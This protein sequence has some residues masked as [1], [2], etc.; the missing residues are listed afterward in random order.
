MQSLKENDNDHFNS[1]LICIYNLTFYI[2][3]INI[4]FVVN[5][6]A[7]NI[8]GV[9]SACNKTI[10]TLNKRLQHESNFCV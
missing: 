5:P 4:G 6:M 7:R 2:K 10:Y 8:C 3:I 1:Q 9:G